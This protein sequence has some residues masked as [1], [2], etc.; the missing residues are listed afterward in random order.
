MVAARLVPRRFPFMRARPIRFMGWWLVAGFM[1]VC[2]SSSPGRPLYTLSFSSAAP[3][4]ARGDDHTLIRFG[5]LKL[6]LGNKT[7]MVLEVPNSEARQLLY[8]NN[9]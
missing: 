7:V 8:S 1:A 4:R 5:P 2:H 6:C 3:A 9:G